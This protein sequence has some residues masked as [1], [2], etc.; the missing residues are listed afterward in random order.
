MGLLVATVL[1]TPAKAQLPPPAGGEPAASEAIIV[2]GSRIRRVL[3]ESPVPLQIFATEDLRRESINSPEQFIAFLTS[4]G[5][6]LDNLASNADVVSG[7]ARGNN[8]ASS[9]NLR[10]Q[11]AAATLILLNGRRVPAH[12]LNGGVVDINQIPLF[13]V[14]R[15]E[16]L[17][18]GASAIYG[19]DAVG[20]VI[21]FITDRNFKGVQAQAFLDKTE[22]GGGDIFRASFK[23]GVGDLDARGFNIMGAVSVSEHRELRG[24]Q[25]SFVN[26]FQPNRG[27][28]VDTRGTPFAT[29]FPLG[30]GPNTPQGTIIASGATAPFIPGTSIRAGGGINV[31][32]L[33]GGPGCNVIDGMD[34]YDELL[35]DIPGARFACAWDTGR[36]AVL[37][38]PIKTIS[39]IVRGTARLGS[40][41]LFAELTGSDADSA[42]RFSN[43]Q[44]VPNTTT[45]NF[46]YPR[47]AQNAAV[48][49]RVFNALVAAFPADALLASRRGLPIAYRWRCIECGRREI[50]TNT[51]TLRASIGA[52][53]PIAGAWE[54][55]LAGSYGYSEAVS[56]LGSGYYF[57]DSVRDAQGNIVER[58]IIDALNTG[59][60]NPF[61]LPGESQS[62]EALALL[63]TASAR[64]VKLY[65]GKFELI[66]VDGSVA[67]PLFDLPAGK[68]QLAV[69]FDY[70]EEKYAFNGDE[71]AERRIII[72]APFDNANA[73][74]GVTRTVKAAYAEALFPVFTGFDLTAA[75]RVDDYTGF[76]TTWNPKISARWDFGNGVALR[77]SYNTGFRVPSFNQIFNGAI[78][79]VYGGADIADPR[80]CPGGRVDTSRPGCDSIRPF[81]INGGK[82][83]LGP[84]DNQQ[85]NLGLVLTP[86]PN[87]FFSFDYWNI[88]RTGTIQVLA[89]RTLLENF[90]LFPDRFIRD[91][92]GNLVAIDQRWVNAGETRTEGLEITVRGGGDLGPGR[93]GFGFDGSLL[94]EKRSQLIPGQPFGPSEVGLF[95]FNGDL[96]LPWRHNAYVTYNSGNW[97]FSLTQIH[98][99]GYRN[100]L[101]P[102]VTSGRV[103][104]PDLVRITEDYTIY[105]ASV[106]LE[107]RE[108]LRFTAGIRNL[109][110]TDPPF[111]AAYDS[112][113][114]GGSSWEPRVAD[115]RGRS[116]TL[117]VEFRY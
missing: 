61:L 52:E 11:G 31:L 91:G 94:L 69:G 50:E 105:N 87:W 57:R 4:N 6:G 36:A 84:E 16:V 27:L 10:N 55:R 30:V 5:N 51:K 78:E 85:Y 12:G 116:F 66:Q 2:T 106:T 25:R 88:R 86:G 38:Q 37:Q 59:I 81:I 47:T 64:G 114:G 108:F 113:T 26:T 92:Q 67:G 53:G 117:L 35:W 41:E 43:L 83:D 42:K 20:G 89:L 13:A 110:D 19:T 23:G 24:E 44:L 21:N 70:R 28:S 71:R 98:R 34:A 68:A 48:Y 39:Y 72:A 8:G 9:A 77:G 90:E 45:Q 103:N 99:K 93:W 3:E 104:P 15:I 100:Q 60:I 54:Y 96:G 101:L 62:A 29:I 65:G 73:L 76:G 46:A 56:V 32:D 102:G 107:P 14:G 115:P 22:A 111:A 97:T 7:Q 112:N 74:D 75:L 33:P 82:P 1:A 63:E 109:F 58:G 95:T 49:D 40:H 80:N 18:D 17:K 79:Q